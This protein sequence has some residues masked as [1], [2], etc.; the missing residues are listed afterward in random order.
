MI[1]AVRP[2]LTL[3]LASA[4]LLWL[5]LLPPLGC[6]LARGPRVDSESHFL[7][8]TS[9][10]DCAG[11]PGATCANGRCVDIQSGDPIQARALDGSTAGDP[12][13][14]SCILQEIIPSSSIADQATLGLLEGCETIT[15]D[16]DLSFSADLRPLY[17]LREVRGAFTLHPDNA[18]LSSLEGL[19]RLELVSGGLALSRLALTSLKSLSQLRSVGVRSAGGLWIED[20]P[21]LRDLSGLEGL[22][23][24]SQVILNKL[25]D[26]VSIDAL[27]LPG[28]LAWLA[29]Q[30]VPQLS[31]AEGLRS[32]G[33]VDTVI[34]VNTGLER[35]DVLAR[36]RIRSLSVTGNSRLIDV[37]GLAAVEQLELSGNALLSSLALPQ[38]INGLQ[39]LT[40]ER[41]PLLQ[42]ITGLDQVSFL[43][44]LQVRDNP[45]LAIVRLPGLES[46]SRLDVA[47][48]PSLTSIELPVLIQPV[49]KLVV[50]SNTSLPPSSLFSIA[51][52][53]VAAKLAGNQGEPRGL[54]PCPYLRDDYC[55]AA[56]NDNLCA[57][58]TDQ[59]DCGN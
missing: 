46:L 7:D 26:L 41:N 39:T 2:N 55:D 43:D 48:N 3:S 35:L 22:A 38:R 56:P 4:S 47:R 44:A 11:V 30:D 8:C 10:T 34:L 37:T 45:A 51:G 28:K 59:F 18:P 42:S 58:G 32:V 36:Q 23:D 25:P 17:A 50:V 33:V 20:S 19:E 13:G 16:L 27:Q 52:R 31:S 15:G 21:G 53:A 49:Q 5:G 9:E 1:R 57:R 40:I 54:D 6:G 29:L 24:P 14:A 12:A